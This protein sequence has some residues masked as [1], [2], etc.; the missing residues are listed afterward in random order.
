MRMNRGLIGVLKAANMW[1]GGKK[2]ALLIEQ[3]TT[4]R[5]ISYVEKWILHTGEE[6]ILLYYLLLK[7]EYFQFLY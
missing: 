1:I 6:S 5:K 7:I 2:V 3:M 4:H